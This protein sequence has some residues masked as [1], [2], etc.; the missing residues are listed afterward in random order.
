[1]CI[2]YE[3]FVLC[4]SVCKPVQSHIAENETGCVALARDSPLSAHVDRIDITEID[5][6]GSSDEFHEE[7][8]PR[9]NAR[10]FVHVFQLSG[11]G[12]R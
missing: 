6:N 8:V 11:V 10:L 1:M 12:D 4:C 7:N 3:R 9:S 5:G 2:L